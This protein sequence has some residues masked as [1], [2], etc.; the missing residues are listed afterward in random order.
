M[1]MW[2]WILLFV[3]LLVF[4]AKMMDR[5]GSTGASKADDLPWNR[6]GRAGP[7]DSSH[8]G[9]GASDGGGDGGG[10]GW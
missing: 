10:G 9:A 8:G 7:F 3:A 4:A 2:V 6:R 1:W 5:R